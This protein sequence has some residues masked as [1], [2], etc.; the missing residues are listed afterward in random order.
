M[1]NNLRPSTL[2]DI[3]GQEKIKCALEISITSANLR[4]EPLGHCLLVGGAGLGKTTLAKIVASELNEPIQVLNAAAIS[5]HKDLL[6][7]LVQLQFRSVL[8]IDEIHRLNKKSQE[9]LF[10]V[11]EDFT[12]T[13]STPAKGLEVGETIEIDLPQFF[14][15]QAIATILSDMDAE[16]AAL[17]QRRDKT[18]ALKQGMMQ[19]LLTGK[20]RLI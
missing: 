8:F 7:Y 1:I 20:I 5:S 13:L 10:P 12:L 11:L 19:E 2:K 3:I 17:E 4:N 6:G 14:E 18:H 15:Q 16:I 9:F